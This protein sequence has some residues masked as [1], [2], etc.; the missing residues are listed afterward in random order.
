MSEPRAVADYYLHM[1]EAYCAMSEEEKESFRDWERSNVTPR[2]RLRSSDWPGWKAHLG[3][4]PE[5]ADKAA[6]EQSAQA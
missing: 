6:A 3:P 5:E 1:Y 2:S 4:R